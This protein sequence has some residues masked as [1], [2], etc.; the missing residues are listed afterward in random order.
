MCVTG[1]EIH[2][3]QNPHIKDVAPLEISRFLF[4]FK[5]KIYLLNFTLLSPNRR[6]WDT[7][8]PP[9]GDSSH[10]N[11]YHGS[12]DSLLFGCESLESIHDVQGCY[13][14]QRNQI[15]I[16]MISMQYQAITVCSLVR[17]AVY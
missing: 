17:L 14:S 1:P 8:S 2:N 11:L 7:K 9:M 16:G 3:P 6:S 10:K 12:A 5:I 13:H 4:L 15:F